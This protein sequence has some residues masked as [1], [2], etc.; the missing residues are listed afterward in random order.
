MNYKRNFFNLQREE[1]ILQRHQKKK[2]K[3]GLLGILFVIP[4]KK[5]FFY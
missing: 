1:Q 3:N 5:S 2:W 4:R